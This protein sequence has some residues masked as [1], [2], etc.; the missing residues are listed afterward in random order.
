MPCA[1]RRANAFHH[2]LFEGL[3]DGAAAPDDVCAR[4]QMYEIPAAR[5]ST[6]SLTA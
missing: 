3:P 4:M 5:S 6:V 2:V 1:P